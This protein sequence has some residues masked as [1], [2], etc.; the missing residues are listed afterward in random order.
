VAPGQRPTEW[1]HWSADRKSSFPLDRYKRQWCLLFEGIEAGNGR[2]GDAITAAEAAKIAAAFREPYQYARV[3]TAGFY[4]DAG[5]CEL[6]DSAYCYDHW[7][8][9]DTG[10]GH[11]PMGH[12]KS[13]DPLF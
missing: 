10:Y 5:F 9:S 13:L 3:H 7:D 2:G 1:D 11:C 4:D 6:C 12:G 8:V